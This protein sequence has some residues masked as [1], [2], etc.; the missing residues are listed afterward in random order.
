MT[1]KGGSNNAGV[2]F[3]FDPSSSTYTKLVDYNGANG[4]NPG[5][6]S[7]FIEGHDCITDTTYYRDADGDGFGNPADSILACSQ[8][9]GYV[10]NNTDC[11]DG[12]P[13]VHPG[14]TEVCNGIDDDCN[15]QVDDGLVFTR[16]YPDADGDG[17]GTGTGQSIVQNPRA[18]ICYPGR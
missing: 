2:I 10:A 16:Y 4:A 7:A 12:N 9:I 1:S 8:P 18:G 17:Y 11:N 3:S 13:A 5:L 14:A 15:G 6:G